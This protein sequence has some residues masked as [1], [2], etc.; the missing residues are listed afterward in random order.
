MGTDTLLNLDKP[1]IFFDAN[2]LLCSRFVKILLRNDH[3][4]LYFAGFNSLAARKLLTDDLRHNPPTVVF[5]SSKELLVKSEA[6]FAILL[7]LRY[8]WPLFTVFSILPLSFNNL[9]YDWVARNRLRWFGRSESCFLP[10]PAQK[11]RF[12]D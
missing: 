8:P 6:I 11:S 7:H 4:K 10:K 12:L 5:Y 2:C 3:H 9:I 1:V